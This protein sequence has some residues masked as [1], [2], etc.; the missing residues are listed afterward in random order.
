M[1]K[2]TSDDSHY[3]LTRESIIQAIPFSNYIE[4]HYTPTRYLTEEIRR[5]SQEL[6]DN[7]NIKP[8]KEEMDKYP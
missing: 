6:L 1:V 8:T 5:R 3:C 7:E 4:A 2:K